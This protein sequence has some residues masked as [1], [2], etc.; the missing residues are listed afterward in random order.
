MQMEKN[1][2]NDDRFCSK[3][4]TMNLRQALCAKIYEPWQGFYMFELNFMESVLS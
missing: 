3:L 2:D 4:M 1:I